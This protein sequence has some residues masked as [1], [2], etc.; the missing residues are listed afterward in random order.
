[1]TNINAKLDPWLIIILGSVLFMPFLGGVN[2]F[3]WD[4]VNFADLGLQLSRTSRALKL[5]ISLHA[6]GLDAFRTA[7]E[8]SLGLREPEKKPTRQAVPAD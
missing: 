1:M 2:L 4:E 5:R 7:I 6:F 3:D 8:R